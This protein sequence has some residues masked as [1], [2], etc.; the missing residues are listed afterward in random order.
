MLQQSNHLYYNTTINVSVVCLYIYYIVDQQRII[1][2]TTNLSCDP[3]N[4]NTLNKSISGV[5]FFLYSKTALT[6]IG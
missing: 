4:I 5:C 2:S 1:N 3:T 6:S